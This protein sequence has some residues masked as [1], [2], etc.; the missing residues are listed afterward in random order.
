ME[1]EQYTYDEKRQISRQLKNITQ[2]HLER[3]WKRLKEIDENPISPFCRTGNKVIDFF[4]LVERL[5]T[6]G[7]KGYSYYDILYNFDTLKEQPIMKQMIDKT[8]RNTIYK[9]ARDIKLYYGSVNIFKATIARQLYMKYKPNTVLDF[10]MGWGGRLA[11]ACSL[12]IPK[13][14][15]I[16]SNY[17]LEKCYKD[18]VSWIQ[19]KSTTT[20]ELFFTDCLKIDYSLLN[21]DMVLTS[22]PYYN[23]EIYTGT[24]RRT[25]DEWDKEFYEPIFR[26]TFKHLQIGGRYC[27]NI[28]QEILD[29]VAIG[30][31]GREYEMIP[32]N[33]SPRGSYKEYIYV[34]TRF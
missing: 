6:K 11:G 26:E 3:D 22:P 2:I 24:N 25:K 8:N 33:I 34:W 18:M 7:R 23:F 1:P 21:Y 5:N 30:V 31:L 27:L 28:N 9:Q 14:I 20:V 4:S 12:N 17:N 15:G 29:R 19:N 32:L 13:Y 10:T 16:D